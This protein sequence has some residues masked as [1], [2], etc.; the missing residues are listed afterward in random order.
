MGDIGPALEP[1]TSRS[2]PNV[3]ACATNVGP[4]SPLEN[5]A[6]PCHTPHNGAASLTN[7]LA[8][9]LLGFTVG[10]RI[11]ADRRCDLGVLQNWKCIATDQDL[12]VDRRC[13]SLVS[14]AD[15]WECYGLR[16]RGAT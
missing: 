14:A 9:T 8:R 1:M 7:V 2:A 16:G 4:T 10:L 3:S 6:S 15:R 13:M 11:D 12:S 5:H